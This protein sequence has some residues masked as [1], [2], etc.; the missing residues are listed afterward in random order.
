MAAVNEVHENDL[1]LFQSTETETGKQSREWVSYRPVNQLTD[2]AALEFN[3]PATSTTYVDLKNIRLHVK[4]KITKHDDSVTSSE[5]DKVGPVNAPLH[6]LFSQVDLN[7]QQRPVSEVGPHYPYKAYLDTLF[8]TVMT[9]ELDAQLFFEDESD[10][11]ND[12]DPNGGNNGLFLRTKFLQD[13]VI[14]DLTGNL[15]LDLC[16]QDRLLLNGVPVN[17]KFWQTTDAFRLCAKA[18]SENYKLKIVNAYLEVA[19]VRVN[20]GVLL[21]HAEALK[22]GPALYP[23]SKSVVKTYAIA[24]GQYSFTQDDV[25]QGQVPRRLIVGL[26]SSAAVH[27]SYTTNPYNFHH[28]DCNFVGF[29]VN[30]QSVPSQPLQPNYGANNYSEVYQRLIHVGNNPRAIN[31]RRRHFKDG[32]ALYIIEPFGQYEEGNNRL[33]EKGHTRLELKFG[34]ALPET[35]TAVVYASFPALMKIDESRNVTSD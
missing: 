32:Y 33:P 27:G 1:A 31:I 25:F 18:G 28:Y 21:G 4:V 22:K 14:A 2:G 26:V 7:I 16:Q 12:T 15:K 23:Y 8:N 17:L 11:I 9:E 29:Y 6:S 34:T 30:G 24:S 10:G 3:I 5:T 20:P 35:V 19:N 13:S